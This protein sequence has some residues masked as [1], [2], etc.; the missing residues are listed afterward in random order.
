MRSQT[1]VSLG[2][3]PLGGPQRLHDR[4]KL[5]CASAMCGCGSR[6]SWGSGTQLCLP[7]SGLHKGGCSN[8]SGAHRHE[9]CVGTCG[10]RGQ[11][12]KASTEHGCLG[13]SQRNHRRH[14]HKA[15]ILLLLCSGM[16]PV[17]LSQRPCLLYPWGV[18][19][20]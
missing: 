8:P 12:G 14:L 11:N 13:C 1:Q 20:T 4:Q 15:G 10:H 16:G 7:Q 2:S 18:S 5:E 19:S 9:P 6:V 17:A 3:P